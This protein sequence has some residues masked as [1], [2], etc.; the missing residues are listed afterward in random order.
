[1]KT[2]AL[3]ALLLVPLVLAAVLPAG[4][5]EGCVLTPTGID[6]SAAMYG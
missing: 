5:E 4:A 6:C 3:L 2:T 1:M